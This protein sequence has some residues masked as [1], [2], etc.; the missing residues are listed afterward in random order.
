[1]ADSADEYIYGSDDEGPRGAGGSR[2][3][4]DPG[5][6]GRASGGGQT[7]RRWEKGVHADAHA[8]KEAAD[9]R[10]LPEEEDNPEAKKRKR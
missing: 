10:L 3:G 7:S 4:G 8:L 1:M 2:A 5:K 9:G 6:K